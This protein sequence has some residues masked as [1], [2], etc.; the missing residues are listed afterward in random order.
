[1]DFFNAL[2]TDYKQLI[3][4]ISVI[5]IAFGLSR[6]LRWAIN[7]S[8][9]KSTQNYK[10]D[11]TRLRFF[12]NALTFIIWLVATGT[13]IS[14]IPQLKHLAITLFAGAGILVAIIG[15]AAQE[16]FSNIIGGVFIVIF[17]PFRVGDMI[18]VGSQNYGVV[19]DITLRHTIILN[20]ENKRV[21]VPNSVI[22][23]ETITNDS[24]GDTI[25]C[26]YI[27][28]GISYDSDVQTAIKIIQEES[29]KHPKSFDHRSPK[30]KKTVDQVE[31]RLTS[32]GDFSVNLRAYVW[33]KDPMN[34]MRMH[35]DINKAI[36]VRFDNEGIVIPYPHRTV[37]MKE[38]KPKSNIEKA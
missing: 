18:K 30:E 17:R 36:K 2:I 26:R 37:I 14:L 9:S 32:F 24:I 34:A 7:R 11:L 28:I 19:E 21:V 27:E 6:I 35:S 5:V 8:F 12:K 13:I 3:T 31:V 1:M 38:E 22:N 29:I 25:V 23:S 20:F 16:A 10:V 15:F 4:I 33:T